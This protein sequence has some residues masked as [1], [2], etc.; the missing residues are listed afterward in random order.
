MSGEFLSLPGEPSRR[1][2]TPQ[3]INLVLTSYPTRP[4]VEKVVNSIDEAKKAGIHFSEIFGTRSTDKIKNIIQTMTAIGILELINASGGDRLSPIGCSLK[5]D[6]D[7]NKVWVECDTI[8]TAF[9]MT[10]NISYNAIYTAPDGLEY[11]VNV[12]TGPVPPEMAK[13]TV[14]P[15]VQYITIVYPPHK[16]RKETGRLGEF[17]KLMLK[18]LLNDPDVLKQVDYVLMTA[19]SLK[20]NVNPD[21]LKL[22]TEIAVDY[23]KSLI[24]KYSGA[25]VIMRMQCTPAEKE[26]MVVCGEVIENAPGDIYEARV[27]MPVHVEGEKGRLF[28]IEIIDNPTPDL[29]ARYLTVAAKEIKG[30]MFNKRP[31]ETRKEEEE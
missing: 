12:K 20:I 8:A 29:S 27:V 28:A 1:K 10:E 23:L 25:E 26:A 18:Q 11:D 9:K 30:D 17:D 13:R 16:P 3:D 14:I 22:L 6:K 31:F 15:V 4:V 2:I 7:E 24:S 19:K 5:W 21:T